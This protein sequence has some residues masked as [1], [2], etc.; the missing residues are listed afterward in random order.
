MILTAA[1]G[2]DLKSMREDCEWLYAN[3]YLNMYEVEN[4]LEKRDFSKVFH[5]N[6]EYLNKR[7]T[8]NEIESVD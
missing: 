4:F 8:T 5:K 1:R 2:E 7:I 6:I 3:I